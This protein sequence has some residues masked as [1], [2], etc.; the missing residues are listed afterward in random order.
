MNR[1][2]QDIVLIGMPGSG[3]STIG[4]LLAKRLKLTIC[5]VDDYIEDKY[6]KTIADIYKI[7][8]EYF[9][10]IE[11]NSIKEIINLYPSIIS[12]GGGIVTNKEGME[13]LG[14]NRVII[15]INR[16]IGEII[17]DID[18]NRPL[19]NNNEN[20]IYEIFEERYDLYK[21]HSDIEVVNSG[22]INLVV[23]ELINMIT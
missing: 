20:R 1:L 15:F 17:K 18:L 5:N 7:G 16:P 4:N 6:K 3:K 19:F 11:I 13:L 22:D 23:D 8:E 2:K 14:D 9:R 12:T 10:E 21:K